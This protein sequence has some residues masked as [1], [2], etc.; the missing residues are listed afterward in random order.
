MRD[1]QRFHLLFVSSI[2]LLAV[3]CGDDDG[4]GGTEADA[5][6]DSG[7]SSGHSGSGGG[8]GNGG[9][10]G[11]GGSGEDPPVD[12]SAP[13]DASRPPEDA[14]GDAGEGE[15]DVECEDRGGCT[16]TASICTEDGAVRCERIA[17][18]CFAPVGEPQECDEDGHQVCRPGLGCVCDEDP[19]CGPLDGDGTNGEGTHC[20]DSE[21]GDTII[22]CVAD[23]DTGCVHAVEADDTRTCAAP[24]VCGGDPGAAD[25]VCPGIGGGRLPGTGCD[26]SQSRCSDDGTSVIVCQTVIALDHGD[27]I[28]C[29][30]WDDGYFVPNDP[31]DPDDLAGDDCQADG[32]SCPAGAN[33]QC[34]CP[35][36]GSSDFYVNAHPATYLRRVLPSRLGLIQNG[37]QRPTICSFDSVTVALDHALNAIGPGNAS[38]SRVILDNEDD[39]VGSID[40]AVP[41]LGGTSAGKA[42]VAFYDEQFPWVVPGGVEIVT[43]DRGEADPR[44]FTVVVD[45]FSNPLDDDFGAAVNVLDT[46]LISGFTLIEG[47]CDI[48]EPATQERDGSLDDYCYDAFDDWP[49]VMVQVLDHDGIRNPARPNLESMHLNGGGGPDPQDSFRPQGPFGVFDGFPEP[50]GVFEVD[51]GTGEV[52]FIPNDSNALEGLA[53]TI[54]EGKTVFVSFFEETIASGAAVHTGAFGPVHVVFDEDSEPIALGWYDPYGSAG[55]YTGRWS[56][57][58]HG[59]D[60]DAEL[61][62]DDEGHSN[63]KTIDVGLLIGRDDLQELDRGLPSHPAYGN[64]NAELHDVRVSAFGSDSY[65][66]ADRSRYGV[67]VDDDYPG[68]P[69]IS[70]DAVNFVGGLLLGNDTGML[71]SDGHVELN[72]LVIAGSSGQGL[73]VYDRDDEEFEDLHQTTVRA[74]DVVIHHTFFGDPDVFAV[75]DRFAWSPTSVPGPG[76]EAFSHGAADDDLNG[77]GINVTGPGASDEILPQ[78]QLVGGFVSSNAEN[79]LSIVN[80]ANGSG[81]NDFA[82]IAAESTAFLGNGRDGIRVKYGAQVQLYGVEIANNGDN[83]LHVET[84]VRGGSAGELSGDIELIG[85]SIHDNGF[86]VVGSGGHGILAQGDNTLI[87]DG[88]DGGPLRVEHNGFGGLYADNGRMQLANTI[89][90][91]NGVND[92]CADDDEGHFMQV[93]ITADDGYYP[94]DLE[95]ET[96]ATMSME[97]CVVTEGFGG[98]IEIDSLGDEELANTIAGTRVERNRGRRDCVSEDYDDFDFF[99]QPVPQDHGD[100]GVDRDLGEPDDLRAYAERDG[101]EITRDGR[102]FFVDEVSTVAG[103]GADSDGDVLV[104]H[105]DGIEVAGQLPLPPASLGEPVGIIVSGN[106]GD[107]ITVSC[108]PRALGAEAPQFS[109]CGFAQLR[110]GESRANGQNGVVAHGHLFWQGGFADPARSYENGANG[111]FVDHFPSTD[112]DDVDCS[113]D[114]GLQPCELAEDAQDAPDLG[115]A[116]GWG[117][118]VG[119]YRADIRTELLDVTIDGNALHGVRID[120]AP[121]AIEPDFA[122][123]GNG[124]LERSGAPAPLL[125]GP[126]LDSEIEDTDPVCEHLTGFRIHSTEA[127]G[128]STVKHNGGW[129]FMIGRDDQESNVYAHVADV[130]VYENLLGGIDV[131]QSYRYGTVDCADG[132]TSVEC[133]CDDT[134]L[135]HVG[136]AAD[137]ETVGCTATTILAN[138]IFNNGGPGMFI[139]RSQQKPT[140]TADRRTISSNDIHHNAIAGVGCAAADVQSYSQVHFEGPVITTDPDITPEGLEDGSHPA[141]LTCFLG[142]DLI[143]PALSESECERMTDP[144]DLISGGVNNHCLWTGTQCRVA[145]DMAGASGD[146]GS[147]DN[148]IFAYVDNFSAPDYTQKGLVSDDGA[149]VLARRNTWGVGGSDNATHVVSGTDGEIDF[150]DS[151]GTVSICTG[152]SPD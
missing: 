54:E 63:R 56:Y 79:G 113:E 139:R 19:A 25:C 42:R 6:A 135:L 69:F 117:E 147:S 30:V 125:A 76:L 111:V 109:V 71:V 144:E 133:R 107:G 21:A 40:S 13:D 146:C 12:A 99:D 18:G 68:T 102:L 64:T 90:G 148:R 75:Q 140:A 51:A 94:R 60:F 118:S 124:C 38:R 110:G 121:F 36:N 23:D 67:I 119:S 57:T 87:T 123:E 55:T 2:A 93:T 37:S 32:L 61:L 101:I 34:V 130:Q 41:P 116:L 132:P 150:G 91:R 98:G 83:G 114:P 44:D 7:Q 127:F 149:R 15:D 108:G 28:T 66:M 39:P 72:A 88:A 9:T 151:C 141:D 100:S 1:M 27:E 22:T 70:E 138:N 11:S 45:D 20:G 10:G 16:S 80:T 143:A 17:G 81:G 5:G 4:D 120:A 58:A 82:L 73:E 96:T 47:G 95:G 52:L 86:E 65:S 131:H 126:V 46:G 145:W 35:A 152:P 142:A 53:D 78:L 59:T 105:V 74:I 26:V 97:S 106:T 29:S 3:A 33:P 137:T 134:D 77:N 89:F 24:L 128:R 104:E 136:L 112:I 62:V 103:N 48:R 84:S 85:G 122:P 50:D 115:H 43:V 14:G 31:L 92:L 8:G 49:N 129:A